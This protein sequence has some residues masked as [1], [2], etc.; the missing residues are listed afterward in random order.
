MYDFRITV[1]IA[2]FPMATPVL[3]TCSSMYQLMNELLPAEWLPSKQGYCEQRLVYK[4]CSVQVYTTMFIVGFPVNEL[5]LS[6]WF[7]ANKLIN[8][9]Y[10]WSVKIV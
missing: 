5:L 4:H 10:F 2:G 3:W 1:F 8:D 7:L 9:C 6:D